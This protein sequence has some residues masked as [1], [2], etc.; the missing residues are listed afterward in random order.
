V[1]FTSRGLLFAVGVLCVLVRMVHLLAVHGTPLFAAH[2]VWPGTDMFFFDQWAQRIVGGDVLGRVRFY[3]VMDWM[4][5]TAPLEYWSRW[6]GNAPIYFKAPLYAYAVALL[7]W[8]FGDPAVPM[9]VL[10]IA[11]SIASAALLF[12]I[13]EQLFGTAAGLLAA[14]VFALYAPAVH[15]DVVMLR[16]PWVI[17][18]SLLVTWRLM[19]LR[20]H[21][22]PAGAGVLGLIVGVALLLNESFATLP[23]LVLAAF[24]CWAPSLRRWTTASAGFLTGLAIAL[25]P[26][27]V[28]NIAVGAPPLAVAVT[29]AWVVAL[30]NAS[31]SDPIIFG[32]PKPSF[33]PLME[34]GGGRLG[35]VL[36]LCLQSFDGVGQMLAFYLHRAAGL[37]APFENADNASFDYAAIGSPLLRWLPDYAWLFPLLMLGMVL[38]VGNV[39]LR[40]LGA[41]VPVWIALLIPN[42][43]G[44]PL[45]RYR[46]SLVV[47]GMPFAGLALERMWR[48]A[49]QRRLA[50]LVGALAALAAL[51]LVAGLVER[52]MLPAAEPWSDVYRLSDFQVAA[53]EYAKAGRYREASAEYL[54]LADH[55]PQGSRQRVKAL[56]LAAPL[57]ASAGDRAGARASAHAA[58]EECPPDPRILLDIGDV[59]WTALGDRDR[60][61]DAYRRALELQPAGAILDA[62]RARLTALDPGMTPPRPVR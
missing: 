34:A 21:L 61:V 38:A 10:Q 9:A 46:L 28:R 5:A 54:A 12:L 31:D 56:L 32:F 23:F 3:P 11:A 53:T 51:R 33:V 26:L 55:V 19:H 4:S 49:T 27:V 14:I 30:S 47:L 43:L 57:Q 50:V 41:L 36:W 7:R 8:L 1:A 48:W 37:V 29:G 25:T 60:A 20:E 24:A 42:V 52:R 62:L 45:S 44:P 17:L 15:Y 22:T 58:T 16:G 35:R 40:T 6:F 39:R 13:T 59:H 2:R 18:A